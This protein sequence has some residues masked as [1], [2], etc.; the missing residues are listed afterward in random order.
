M[1][2]DFADI[3]GKPRCELGH[4]SMPA[5]NAPAS[6]AEAP[7]HGVWRCSNG[8]PLPFGSRPRVAK[9]L[10]NR[11]NATSRRGTFSGLWSEGS[12]VSAVKYVNVWDPAYSSRFLRASP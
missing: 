9:I 4:Q 2:D 6:H 7:G 12:E 3:V 8:S 1:K 11:K 5:S 10:A